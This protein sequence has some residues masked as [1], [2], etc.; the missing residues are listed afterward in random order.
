MM[1]KGEEKFLHAGNSNFL[2][3]FSSV[4]TLIFLFPSCVMCGNV[5]DRFIGR[6][7]TAPSSLN[8][9]LRRI[10]TCVG[11]GCHGTPCYKQ[12]EEPC[13]TEN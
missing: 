4:L 9:F 11:C 5:L 13:F 6:P 7:W 3:A 8:D 1:V 2:S 10:N 12:E